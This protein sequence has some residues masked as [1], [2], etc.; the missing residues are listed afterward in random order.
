MKRILFIHN[1]LAE[2]RLECFRLISK[3]YDI[4]FLIVS[5]DVASKIYNFKFDLGEGLNIAYLDDIGG[6]LCLNQYIK[7]GQYDVV[8][9]PPADTFRDLQCG[10]IAL[11]AAKKIKAKTVFWTEKWEADRNKQPFAKWVKNRIHALA[12][13]LLTK[14]VTVCVAAST[15]T[16]L[17]FM[18]HIGIPEERIIVLY[19]SNIS[20]K[21]DVQLNIKEIYGFPPNSE[22]I[23]F[24]GR[25]VPRKGCDILI[26]AFA[27]VVKVKP[28][29]CLLIVGEGPSLTECQQLAGELSI[30]HIVFAGKVEPAKRALYY[31]QSVVSC[32]PSYSY[33]GIIEAYGLTVNESLEQGT[34]VVTTTAVGAGHDLHDGRTCI[35]VEENDKNALAGALIKVLEDRHKSETR[36]LCVSKFREFSVE[37]MADNFCKSFEF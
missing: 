26:K 11:K 22:I 27:D 25:L 12:I 14:D 8:V 15:R 19:H 33:K 23:L 37:R 21:C 1:A 13:R 34:P 6:I 16:K 9:I 10:L 3:R 18:N 35:M 5:K 32:L 17:Y 4:Q 24:L 28:N 36:E 29:A 30:P 7:K 20:P 31:Q 2:Y